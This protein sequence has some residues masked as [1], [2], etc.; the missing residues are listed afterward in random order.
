MT[1]RSMPR[2]PMA[3]FRNTVESDILSIDCFPALLQLLIEA[4]HG[5]KTQEVSQ[6]VSYQA[7]FTF[8]LHPGVD[9]QDHAFIVLQR[10]VSYRLKM[11]VVE[12]R[13][14]VLVARPDPAAVD[15]T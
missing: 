3:E 14:K 12:R 10:R 9:R 5:P 6:V 2:N 4:Y 8:C 13:I 1:A 11:R 15:A 7:M